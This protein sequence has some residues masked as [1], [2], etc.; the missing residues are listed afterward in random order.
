ME[1]AWRSAQRRLNWSP[2]TKTASA[3]FKLA[4]LKL[5]VVSLFKHLRPIVTDGSKPEILFIIAQTIAHIQLGKRNKLAHQSD[6]YIGYFNACEIWTLTTDLR[7][8][9]QSREMRPIHRLQLLCLC[10]YSVSAN[11]GHPEVMWSTVSWNCSHTLQLLP[12][13]MTFARRYLVLTAWSCAT[14]F[15]PVSDFNPAI[16][17]H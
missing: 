14:K 12:S 17:S 9:L 11:S 16:F 15:S 6:G 1:T 4:V 8:R 7:G 3:L 13:F 2:I 5:E 10:R